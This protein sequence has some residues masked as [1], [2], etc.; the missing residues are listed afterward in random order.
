MNKHTPGP[1]IMFGVKTVPG[2]LAQLQ[3]G[4]SDGE[5]RLTALVPVFDQERAEANA[6]LIAAA[7][8][9]LEILK[10]LKPMLDEKLKASSCSA[11]FP[12]IRN[13][14]AII[15]KLS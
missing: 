9:M 15:R 5:R 10:A 2:L 6:E 1:W 3:V 14:L 13:A 12:T 4:T 11:S 8:E 7:P